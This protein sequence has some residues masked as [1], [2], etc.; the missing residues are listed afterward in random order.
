MSIYVYVAL[1]DGKETVNGK[2]EA[3]DIRTARAKIKA[4]NLLPV[5]IYE[6]TISN[7]ETQQKNLNPTV[8]LP[9]L[10]LKDKIDFSSFE[11]CDSCFL[12][13]F[14][15]ASFLTCAILPLFFPAK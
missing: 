3:E 15:P 6:E 11:N 2:I 4:L 8:K 14:K 9:S 5:K 1:R 13:D 7:N 12:A 10:S